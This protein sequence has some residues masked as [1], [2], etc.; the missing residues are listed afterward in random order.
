MLRL[1]LSGVETVSCI[2]VAVLLG[3]TITVEAVSEWSGV[4]FL[5]FGDCVC[6]GEIVYCGG[7]VSWD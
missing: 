5:C 4:C 2:V 6:V 3:D 7:C 1:F